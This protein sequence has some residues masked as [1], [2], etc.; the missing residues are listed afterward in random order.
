MRAAKGTQLRFILYILSSL[1][2]LLK[3]GGVMKPNESAKEHPVSFVGNQIRGNTSRSSS[4][5]MCYTR[6]S[7]RARNWM[8]WC[9]TGLA[10]SIVYYSICKMRATSAK[11][12]SRRRTC[13]GCAAATVLPHSM[14]G[15]CGLYIS[16]SFSHQR[17][18][19]LR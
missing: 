3:R 13:C 17:C 2:K 11:F 9:V 6:S 15:C 4:G 19:E 18:F 16:H 8:L 12:P 10:W 1:H 7:Y 5:K 14:S